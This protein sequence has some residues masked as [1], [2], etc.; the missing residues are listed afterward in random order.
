MIRRP[1]RS[2][3]FPYTTLFRSRRMALGGERPAGG[4]VVRRQPGRNAGARAPRRAAALRLLPGPHRGCVLDGGDRG[5][6]RA[7]TLRE[8]RGGAGGGPLLPPPAEHTLPPMPTLR[9]VPADAH[10]HVAPPV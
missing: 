3:L 7:F 5:G 10:T 2:T 9:R 4:A 1:P 8:S 6:D